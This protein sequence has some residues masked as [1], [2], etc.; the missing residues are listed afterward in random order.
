MI[1]SSHTVPRHVV[2]LVQHHRLHPRQ[3]VVVGVV[4]LRVEHV[5]EDL[6]GH[7]HHLGL[8]VQAE[9]AGEQAHPLGPELL[10]E[11]PKLLVGEGLEGR[12]VKDLLTMVQGTMN[13]VFTHQG[14]AR[15]RGGT[16]H[17]RVALVEGVD[18]FELEGVEGEGE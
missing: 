7:H 11:I 17:H 9:I 8:P 3:G 4:D 5:A 14:L 6:R 10:A 15:T 13:R 1:D 2:A 18:R 12:G 16:H